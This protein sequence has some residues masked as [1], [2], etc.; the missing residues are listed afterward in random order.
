VRQAIGSINT[1]G[2]EVLA[3]DLDSV[4]LASAAK[5]LLATGDND[6]EAAAKLMS[7]LKSI[8]I[9][10][11]EIESLAAYRTRV[12][13]IRDVL[14]GPQWARY[15]T[16]ASGQDD[17]ELWSGRWGNEPTGVLLLSVS[18]GKQVFVMHVVGN[19]RPDQ[20]LSLSGQLGIPMFYLPLGPFRSQ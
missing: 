17:M 6:D 8:Q 2:R 4:L 1:G 14:K 5:S 3:M 11:F 19:L 12:Q 15:A 18:K 16:Y 7:G 13:P 20:L 10:A 9:R